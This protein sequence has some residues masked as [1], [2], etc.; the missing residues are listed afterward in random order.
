MMFS[1]DEFK[2]I[3]AD[4]FI[5]AYNQVVNFEKTPYHSLFIQLFAND[6]VVLDVVL[7]FNNMI[8]V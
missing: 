5:T 7:K 4:K 3:L 6:Y 1:L 8:H 2:V